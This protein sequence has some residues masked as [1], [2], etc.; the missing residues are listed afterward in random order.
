[1][2]KVELKYES[3]QAA[4]TSLNKAIMLFNGVKQLASDDFKN[5]KYE[6]IVLAARDSLI[7]RFEFTIELFW[8][9]LKFY[10]EEKNVQV[11]ANTPND[12]IRAACNAQLISETDAT[13]FIKMLKSRNLTSHIYKEEIAEILSLEIA[14]FYNVLKQNIDQ[15]KNTT[16]LSRMG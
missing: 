15:L 9:Y 13:L 10:L 4:L 6:D 1:M 3:L 5:V 11:Q 2:A 12:V 14:S 7:Q 8:K 16:D